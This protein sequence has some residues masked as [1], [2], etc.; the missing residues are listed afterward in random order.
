MF[1]SGNVKGKAGCGIRK[2]IR[3]PVGFAK[4]PKRSVGQVVLVIIEDEDEEGSCVGK[5][6]AAWIKER[7]VGGGSIGRAFLGKLVER[8]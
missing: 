6:L 5:V 1:A 7:K 4:K 2:R 8:S 3:S